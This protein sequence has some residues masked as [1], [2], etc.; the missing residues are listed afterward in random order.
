[1]NLIKNCVFYSWLSLLCCSLLL[2][3]CVV[4]LS[5]YYTFYS[6]NTIIYCIVA[7]VGGFVFSLILCFYV[8]FLKNIIFE[9]RTIP[10]QQIDDSHILNWNLISNSTTRTNNDVVI[11]VSDYIVKVENNQTE[12]LD[13]PNAV[14]V[15]SV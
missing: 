7:G 13:I 9:R 12:D 1:M 3:F 14:I 10:V 6:N 15:N 8:P 11:D 5:N 4:I 2:L